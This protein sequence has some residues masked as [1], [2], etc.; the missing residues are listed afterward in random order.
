MDFLLA[1]PKALSTLLEL[2]EANFPIF[3]GNAI[4]DNG[5]REHF[6]AAIP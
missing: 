5:G 6:E 3:D 4:T 2:H 1:I